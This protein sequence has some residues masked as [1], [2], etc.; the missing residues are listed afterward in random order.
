MVKTHILS[1]IA[2]QKSVIATY[3]KEIKTRQ[4][5]LVQLLT[6]LEEIEKVSEVVPD[7]LDYSDNEMCYTVNTS[8]EI[9]ISKVYTASKIGTV[10][11][12]RRLFK[13]KEYA[14]LFRDKSQFI[15]DMLHFKYLYDRDFK[16][17]C[18]DALQR[19]YM[20][21]YDTYNKRYSTLSDAV[22]FSPC[23]VYFSTYEIAEACAEWMNERTQSDRQ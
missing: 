15:A 18:N 1:E 16:A 11:E 10:G 19:S 4:K 3:E 22:N 7:A 13:T 2:H 12:N 20:V 6:K 17:D 5:K 14:E 21:V 23:N 8:G 9:A